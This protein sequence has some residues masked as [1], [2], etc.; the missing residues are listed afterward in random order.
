MIYSRLDKPITIQALTTSTDSMGATTESWATVSNS[1][2]FAQ[3]IPL[4]GS[5][6]VEMGKVT[7]NQV[8]KPRIRRHD[9]LTPKHRVQVDS[10]NAKILSIE[11]YHRREEMILWCE[12]T[13]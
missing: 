12:V 1:P 2:S 4:K 6:V 8:F 13:E 7:S 9:G 10:K 5:E 11:D 3:Y